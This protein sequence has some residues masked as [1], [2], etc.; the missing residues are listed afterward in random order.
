MGCGY[1]DFFAFTGAF[2]FAFTGLGV[3]AFGVGAFTGLGVFAFGVGGFTGDFAFSGVFALG[4]EFE[5]E[6]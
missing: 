3:F 1:L 4:G 5:W 6:N 2:G